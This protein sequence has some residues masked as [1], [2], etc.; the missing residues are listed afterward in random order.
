MRQLYWHN[1]KN[2]RKLEIFF[3][4]MHVCRCVD[5]LCARTYSTNGSPTPGAPTQH[6]QEILFSKALP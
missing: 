4:A 6:P 2:K 1:C 5:I 3:I